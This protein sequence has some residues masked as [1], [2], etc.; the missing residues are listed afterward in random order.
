MRLK[1]LLKVKVILIMIANTLF[2]DFTKFG[3]KQ[4]EFVDKTDEELKLD[5]ETKELKL[6]VLLKWLSSKNDFN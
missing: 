2:T 1:V 6:N 3:Y 5:E 4:F